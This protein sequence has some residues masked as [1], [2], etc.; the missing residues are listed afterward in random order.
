VWISKT[1]N[2]AATMVM[3]PLTQTAAE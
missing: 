2:Q 1:R 3:P